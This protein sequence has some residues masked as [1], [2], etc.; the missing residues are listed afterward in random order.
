[1]KQKLVITS[2]PLMDCFGDLSNSW[3]TC[4]DS[5]VMKQK[6]F[7]WFFVLSNGI[8]TSTICEQETIQELWVPQGIKDI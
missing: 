2:L 7:L 8:S 3:T 4:S 6:P 1:M 5:N